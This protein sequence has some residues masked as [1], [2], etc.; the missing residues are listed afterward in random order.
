MQNLWLWTVEYMYTYT[1]TCMQ[2][3]AKIISS[4][5]SGKIQRKAVFYEDHNHKAENIVMGE[6]K[7][8]YINGET[9]LW[10]KWLGK[11]AVPQVVSQ[12][13][14]DLVILL[15]GR[16]KNENLN[17]HQIYIPVFTEVLLIMDK[18]QKYLNYQQVIYQD[19]IHYYNGTLFSNLKVRI[20][21][22]L[23]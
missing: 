6:N 13:P 4:L 7:T 21:K 1:H 15:L 11:Q 12:L 23:C 9:I 5:A 17:L 3:Q 19:L 8:L 2:E 16:H 22:I 14:S 18:K 20:L 10:W